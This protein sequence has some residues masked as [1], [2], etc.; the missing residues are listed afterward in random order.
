MFKSEAPDV[1]FH[2]W[3]S[4]ILLVALLGVVARLGF[5][6]AVAMSRGFWWFSWGAF[7]AFGLLWLLSR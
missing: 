5:I 2:S 3:L 7:V 1:F 4:L 6:Y